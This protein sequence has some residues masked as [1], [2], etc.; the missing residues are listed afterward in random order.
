MR[1]IGPGIRYHFTLVIYNYLVGIW[2]PHGGW[3]RRRRFGK[4]WFYLHGL[5]YHPIQQNPSC[6]PGVVR[7]RVF[8]CQRMNGVQKLHH[9]LAQHTVKSE[10]HPS[11]TLRKVRSMNLIADDRRAV[12]ASQ[13]RWSL[14]VNISLG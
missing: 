5:V 2:T 13:P 11:R 1:R 10:L 12:V 9:F 4:M 6:A 8:P 3:N 14:E 7:W